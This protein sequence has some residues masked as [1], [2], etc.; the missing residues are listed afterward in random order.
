MAY[1]L[2]TSYAGASFADGFTFF[3]APD[4]SRGFVRYL[5]RPAAEAGM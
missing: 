2:T 4:P 3:T 1:A 5:P